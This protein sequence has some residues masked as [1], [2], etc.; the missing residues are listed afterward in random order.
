MDYQT[1]LFC[2]FP[3]PPFM[4]LIKYKGHVP[5]FSGDGVEGQ[6]CD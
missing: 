5:L 2:L 1:V 3:P 6:A 4:Y